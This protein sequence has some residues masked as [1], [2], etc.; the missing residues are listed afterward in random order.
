MC[1]LIY[2]SHF[3]A[4]HVTLRQLNKKNIVINVDKRQIQHRSGYRR[5][6][7][8]SESYDLGVLGFLLSS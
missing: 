5:N 3:S 8:V 7:Q 1:L 4:V 2:M 6:L